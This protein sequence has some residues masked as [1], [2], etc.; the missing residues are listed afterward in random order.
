MS[1]HTDTGGKGPDLVMIHGWG[2]HSGIWGRLL[3]LLE[4]NFRVTRV[5]LP[6]H[7]RSDWQGEASLDD[8]VAAVMA[9]VPA[10]AAWLGWSL[11]GLVAMRAALRAPGDVTALL[12]IASTPCFVRKPGWQHAML[13]SLLES[14]AD[15]LARDYQ[16]T[17]ERFLSLQ[18]Q[19]SEHASKVLLDLRARLLQ[20]GEP[21]AAGLSVGLEIL[22]TV[23][24]RD[25][26]GDLACK[27]LLLMGERDKLVPPEAGSA[28][29]ML[30]DD[31]QLDVIRGAGHAP[32]LAA[33]QLVA[34]RI[35]R[36]MC[37]AHVPDR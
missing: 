22:R 25:Q 27:S 16:R 30:L 8:M 19:G 14:F 36:F 17:L 1:L 13:P 3:P 18:V 33:P 23:D 2:L 32:F 37:E 24:L 10:S 15:E 12:S 7:G 5:D 31:A 34:E 11:G 6:G 28:T 20:Q 35:N 26:L 9:V 29:A 4:T 21:D